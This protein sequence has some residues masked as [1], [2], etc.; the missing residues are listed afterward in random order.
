MAQVRCELE[1]VVRAYRTNV[2]KVDGQMG[3]LGLNIQTLGIPALQ[4]VDG[5]AVS[6]ITRS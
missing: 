1:I 5:E 4:R 6:A 2:T 3:Q